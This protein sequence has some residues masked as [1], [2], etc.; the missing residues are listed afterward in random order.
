MCVADYYNYLV[1]I[2]EY[3]ICFSV[4]GVSSWSSWL[5]KNYTDV[6]FVTLLNVYIRTIFM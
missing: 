3:K 4:S 6:V 2:G 5:S 1:H